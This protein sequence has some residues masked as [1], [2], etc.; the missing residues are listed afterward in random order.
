MA[1]QRTFVMIKPDGVQRGLIGE[2]ISRIERKGLKV[3]ALKMVW[4]DKERAERLYDIHKGKHFFDELVSFVTSG[5]VVAMV[6]EGEEAVSVVRRL[7]G[8][9]NPREA[10]PGT[11]RGDF[12]LNLTKNIIHAADSVER[13]KY[14]MSIFFSDDELYEYERCSDRMVY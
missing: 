5:P 1:I 10:S 13:A 9:T 12:G 6:I 8:A 14:E 2:I 7:I 11:I 3:V 4:L